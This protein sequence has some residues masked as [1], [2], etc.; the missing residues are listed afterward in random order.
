MAKE[1][2][3]A[4]EVLSKHAG[5]KPGKLH[6]HEVRVRRGAETKKGKRGYIAEHHMRDEEG[7]S[8]NPGGQAPEY[9]LADKAALDAHMDQHMP[10]EGGDDAAAAGGAAGAG[11]QGAGQ[12]V[13]A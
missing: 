13:T 10:E 5:S 11:G 8:A 12:P 2:D 3:A 4:H 7:N 9:P 6:V 1:Y